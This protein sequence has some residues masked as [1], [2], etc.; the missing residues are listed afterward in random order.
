M[1]SREILE[2]SATYAAHLLEQGFTLKE[3]EERTN[4]Y[5]EELE[6]NDCSTCHG[7]RKVEMG[8]GDNH[9]FRACPDCASLSEV[10]TDRNES[11]TS[12]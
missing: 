3:V 7:E 6:E 8:E 4:D 1:S 11:I 10:E 9:Y 5:I 2:K 12:K